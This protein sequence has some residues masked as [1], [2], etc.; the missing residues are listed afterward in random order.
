MKGVAGYKTHTCEYAHPRVAA[1][2][3][4]L[5]PQGKVARCGVRRRDNLPGGVNF[6]RTEGLA[7]DRTRK[8]CVAVQVRSHEE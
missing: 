4:P 3:A 8:G 1:A 6:P 2:G 7:A 5:R